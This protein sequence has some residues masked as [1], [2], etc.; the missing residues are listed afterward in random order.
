MKTLIT[1]LVLLI[2]VT[3]NA[4]FEKDR[5]NYRFATGS[6]DVINAVK[7]SN[8]TDNVPE[9]N[10]IAK[11]GARVDQIEIGVLYEQFN[12]IG[13]HKYGVE[14]GGIFEPIYDIELVPS[15]ELGAIIREVGK[16]HIGG[17]YLTYAVNLE[18]RYQINELMYIG[19]KTNVQRRTDLAGGL[20]DVDGKYRLSNYLTIGL[21]F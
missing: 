15:I 17:T 4:Q 21:K 5:H 20:A 16:G 19:I 13:F 12:R 3:V 6:I 8:P 9:L 7:G 2:T 14:V 18:T 11:I 1:T 10:Y